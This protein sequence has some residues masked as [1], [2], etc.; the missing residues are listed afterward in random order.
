MKTSINNV[1][2]GKQTL[3]GLYVTAREAYDMWKAD[4]EKV[5]IIDV[6]TPEEYLFVGNPAMAWKIPLASQSYDWDAGER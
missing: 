5:N 3:A 4:P 6:R 2:A 1:P